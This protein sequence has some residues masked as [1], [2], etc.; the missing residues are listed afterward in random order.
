MHIISNN[1][2]RCRDLYSWLC[3]FRSRGEY[4]KITNQIVRQIQANDEFY[5]RPYSEFSDL[6]EGGVNITECSRKNDVVFPAGYRVKARLLPFAGHALIQ[7]AKTC[8][9]RN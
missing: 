1:I 5:R 7:F 4:S 3:E 8:R 9:Q 2:R 6:I